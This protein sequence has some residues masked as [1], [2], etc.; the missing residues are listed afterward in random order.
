[1]QIAV[2]E[3]TQR[4]SPFLPLALAGTLLSWWLGWHFLTA[5]AGLIF[6]LLAFLTQ[7]AVHDYFIQSNH[8]IRRNFPLLGWCRYGLELIGDELRQYWFMAD[9]EETPYNRVTRR[10]IYRSAKGINNNLGF[11]TQRRYRDVGEIH[12][13]P[14]MFPIPDTER[15]GQPAAAYYYRQKPTHSLRL[16]LADQYL[17]HELGCA[18]GKRRYAPSPVV[19]ARQTSTCPPAKVGLTPFHLEGVVLNEGKKTFAFKAKTALSKA[20]FG[21]GQIA[22]RSPAQAARRRPHHL[23]DRTGQIWLP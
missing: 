13:L 2:A 6:A 21:T 8:A 10:Y 22:G 4:Q 5:M 1:M 20:T 23:P 18:F 16:P 7:V 9:T 3:F 11:G 15:V 14:N 12:M 19:R 17:R